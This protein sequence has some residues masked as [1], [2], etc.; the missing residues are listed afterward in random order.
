M[1]GPPLRK[2]TDKIRLETHGV[3]LS[4]HFGIFFWKTVF[5]PELLKVQNG[6]KRRV[7][8][9]SRWHLI[10]RPL[11]SGEVGDALAGRGG[12]GGDH[13]PGRGGGGSMGKKASDRSAR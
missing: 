3:M 7:Q 12:V 8:N 11:I 1:L 5:K 2:G 10:P 4:N 9:G 13:C 6:S